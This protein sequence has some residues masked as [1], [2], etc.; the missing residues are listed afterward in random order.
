[1]RH[2]VIEIYPISLTIIPFKMPKTSDSNIIPNVNYDHK[3]KNT[4]TNKYVMLCH[5][6]TSQGHVGIA[7][8]MMTRTRN[9]KYYHVG[10]FNAYAQ[11]PH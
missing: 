11:M 4:N 6:H 10:E 2:G 5:C 9:L 8:I 1:M 7:P 3:K